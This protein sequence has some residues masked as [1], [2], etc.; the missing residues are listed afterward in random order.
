MRYMK[1]EHLS[2]LIDNHRFHMNCIV[3][4]VL[5]VSLQASVHLLPNSIFCSTINASYHYSYELK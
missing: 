1:I 2:H 3:Q 4:S 5:M